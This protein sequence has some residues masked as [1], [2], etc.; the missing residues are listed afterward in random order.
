[1]ATI[2]ADDALAEAAGAPIDED[3]LEIKVTA[4]LQRSDKEWCWLTFAR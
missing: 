2:V 3:M 4:S 1:M